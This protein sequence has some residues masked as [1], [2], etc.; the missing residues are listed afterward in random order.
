MGRSSD[1][2]SL[3]QGPVYL[4][5]VPMVDIDYDE[6]GAYWG[7]GKPI[8]CAWDKEVATSCSTTVEEL[9][10]LF[11]SDDPRALANA[12]DCVA[13]YHGYDNFDSYPLELN[14]PELDKR[15]S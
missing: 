14:E 5:Q 3:F 1:D 4:E 7:M 6:G 2:V 11:T 15:W 10:K 13:S 12:Y 8:F 9:V